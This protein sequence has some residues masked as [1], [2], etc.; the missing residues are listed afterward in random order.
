M[1]CSPPG[2]S[3]HGIFQQVYWSGLPCPSPGDLSKP[4]I[5]P[6]SPISQADSLPS[7]SP[8]KPGVH[9]KY[10]GLNLHDLELGKSFLD[11]TPKAHSDKKIQVV[12]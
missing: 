8:G 9:A 11:M 1:D 4:A 5:E 10:I 2:L 3:V 12:L 7:E 6:R